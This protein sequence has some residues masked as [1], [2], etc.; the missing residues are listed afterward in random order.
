M[1]RLLIAAVVVLALGGAF[2]VG[3]RASAGS[4]AHSPVA[5]PRV[6]DEVRSALAARYYRPVP[7]SVLQLGSIHKIISALGDPYTTYL[8]PA[9]Y[10]L[11][12]QETASTYEGIGASVLPSRHGFVV[13]SLRPGPAQAAG[14]HVGDT[15][16]RIG[17]TPARALSMSRAMARIMGTPGTR[18][19]LV[20]TRGGKVLDLR[21]ARA[22]IRAPAVHARLISF[23]GRRWGDVQLSAFRIGTSVLLRREL[24]ALQ[25]QGASGFVLDLRQNPG[26]L[27][28]QAV[29]VASLFLNRGV[30][31][32]LQG[33]HQPQQILR[34]IPGVTTELPLVVLVDRYTA[35]A[36]EIVA[37]ALHDHHRATIVGERTFGKALVQAV[38]PLD[39]GA[40]LEL[41]IAHYW[42]P[43]GA[44]L[45]GVGLAP[46]ILAR[47]IPAT[48][49]DEALAV[50]LHVLARPTS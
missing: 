21:V 47:D 49:Q 19:H 5:A 23:A 24:R 18:V 30:I 39:N 38:D 20:L 6:V 4:R 44:D 50:A 43:S 40:A 33:A 16:V 15:I 41:S 35:S 42:T 28:T 17:D 36:A 26:G 37:A 32:S 2:V 11:V 48:P 14:I 45:S 8:G 1:R 7:A 25:A 29:T 34:A 31:V 3:Y 22:L 46:Q 27:L 13:V 12:R 9:S 10:R